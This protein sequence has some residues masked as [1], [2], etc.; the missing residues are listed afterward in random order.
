MGTDAQI[1]EPTCRGDTSAAA[2]PAAALVVAAWRV[3]PQ[4]QPAAGGAVA[5]LG[6]ACTHQLLAAEQ[7]TG[8]LFGLRSFL[9]SHAHFI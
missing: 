3:A 5:R 7:P 6:I 8:A 9:Q 4:L 1:W 2:A